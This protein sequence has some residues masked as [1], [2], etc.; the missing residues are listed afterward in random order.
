MN[1]FQKS[2]SMMTPR[3]KRSGILLLGL[4]VLKGFADTVGVA[5]I[6]PFLSVLGQP[7]V[8][9]TN[10]YASR[11]YDA[12]GFSSI[13]SFLFTLGMLVIFIL[14]FSAVLKAVT[15]YVTNRWIEMRSHSLSRRLLETY[16]KRPYT[17]YLTRNTSDMSTAI[18]SMVANVV[19]GVY[20]PVVNL[21]SSAITLIL[22]VGLLLWA[23]PIVTTASVVA[24]G[25]SYLLLYL[26]L[27]GFIKQKGE[28]MVIANRAKYR[29]V[30]ET[31]SGIKQIKLNSQ[32]NTNLDL[33]SRSSQS[34][35]QARAI[36][37]TLS[38]IPRFGL[39]VI[40]FGGIIILTL[41][42]FERNDGAIEKIIPLIG[43]YAF[44]GYRLLPLLQAIYSSV[45]TLRISIPTVDTIHAD[46]KD[47][48]ELAELPRSEISPMPM[49]HSI[50]LDS[51]SFQYPNSQTAGL[52]DINLEIFKGQR[53]GIVGT[54]GAGKTTLVDVLLGLL[55]VT[56][57][58]VLIDKVSLDANNSR[59]WQVSVG[60]VPQDI[61]LS[62]GSI[63]ENIAMG[64][65]KS[66]MSM[67]K[68][69]RAA[70]ASKLYDFIMN[71]LPDGFNTMVGE[72]GI[73]LSGGQ[74]QRLGIARALYKNP[75]IVIF[76]EA[77]SALDNSTEREL[78]AEISQMSGE[79]TVIMIAHRLST[80]ADC[81]QIIVLDKG[82]IVGKGTHAELVVENQIF[83]RMALQ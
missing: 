9:K 31:F 59:S 41:V 70:K 57:G 83:S 81:D 23:N 55:E 37:G 58:S 32:E 77:T 75:Q 5:S 13:N 56:S 12:L 11:A 51:V 54:T 28:I 49:N 52:E 61:F 3:E 65:K 38:Q 48:H 46:I 2:L 76:D 53:L 71:D 66:Q 20:R 7:E 79:R 14:V 19:N 63:A 60:Y 42:L 68:L 4:T 78:I 6:L 26:C 67:K 74:R 73:R 44:A 62:D 72:R 50:V 80:I 27:K 16:L 34:L 69:E 1:L 22:I 21:F 25:S 47:A 35:A 15:V 24:I 64:T 40:A 30:N 45:A 43:L 17:Y 29:R 10:P 39:E 36:T 82:R 8:V 33:Y 18:L